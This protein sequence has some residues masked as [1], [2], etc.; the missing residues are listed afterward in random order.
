MTQT[1]VARALGIS[2][3]AVGR[4]IARGELKAVRLVNRAM[5]ARAW[6]KE[7]LSVPSNEWTLAELQFIDGDHIARFEDLAARTSLAIRAGATRLSEI[8]PAEGSTDSVFDD[9]GAVGD[10]GGRDAEEE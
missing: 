1:E 2:P 10:D 9:A 8:P 3:A 6:L 7:W 5:V 4:M